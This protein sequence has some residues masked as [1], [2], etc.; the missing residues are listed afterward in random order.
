MAVVPEEFVGYSD[1][2]DEAIAD[3]LGADTPESLYDAARHLPDSGGKRIHPILVRLGFEAVG[4]E[5]I[6]A[7]LPAAV[8]VEL[9]HTTSLSHDDIIDDDDLRRGA[10]SVHSRWDVPTSILSGDLL[11]ARAFEALC[12]SDAAP[13]TT[14]RCCELLAETCSI[15]CEGQMLDAEFE[16]REDVDEAEY[17]EM[18]EQKTGALL[19]A[20]LRIGALVGGA[21][22]ELAAR[23]DRFGT[24]LGV[25]FQIHDEILDVTQSS[26][27]PGEE[28]GSDITAGEETL[29]TVHAR[30]HG[31]DIE[32]S[33]NTIRERLE[34]A[35]SIEYAR[36][37]A[38][39]LIDE[40]RGDLGD[41]P[42]AEAERTLHEFA[43][44]LV[45]RTY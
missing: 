17:V 12:D 24:Q 38:H 9:V 16:E 2:V 36:G 6:E 22:E 23:L 26:T 32:G 33:P 4:G 3:Y 7:V 10:Q 44:Y 40:A 29:I 27:A 35:G 41:L 34:R 39:E 28:G 31:V 30:E 21:E 14:V 11:Y 45:E 20:A 5:D 43:E 25:A 8:A 19:G 37:Y 42:E 13:G 1:R 18:V 15:I